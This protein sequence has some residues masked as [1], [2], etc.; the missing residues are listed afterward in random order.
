M[1]LESMNSSTEPVISPPEKD[2]RQSANWD[3][4]NAPKNYF[5]LVVSQG[6]SAFFAFAA[7]WLISKKIGSEGYGGVIAIIAASQV[8]QILVNWTCYS[9]VRF[10]TEEFVNTA[11]IASTFWL[12]F[13]VLAVNLLL[14]VLASN[15]WFPP[16]ADWLKLPENSFWFVILH[17]AAS[18]FWLHVQFGLQGAKLPRVSGFLLT[19]E[20]FIIL[21]G[22]ILL[23]WIDNLT[24]LSALLCYSISPFLMIF[25]GTFY[26]KPYLFS[27]FSIDPTFIKKI[28]AYS[29]PLLPFSLI[30]YFSGSYVDAIFVS[31]FLS[32][33]DLG[34]YSIATQINGITLQLPTLANSLLLPFFVTLQTGK[35]FEITNQYFKNVLPSLTLFWGVGCILLA[36]AFDLLIPIIFGEE[37]R[38]AGKALWIL[39][40]AS[41]ISASALFGYTAL[42][43]AVSATYISTVA[44]IFS[45]ATNILLN[46]L[47]IPRYGLIGCAWAT[48]FS[49]LIS[50][51]SIIF[52]T[53]RISGVSLSWL[54]FATLPAALG[55]VVFSVWNNSFSGLA[56]SLALA[57]ITMIVFKNSLKQTAIILNNIRKL[58][59]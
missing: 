28:V 20:R 53:Y 26:L 22:I 43:H 16:L 49:Y 27:H 38:D 35:K 7:V 14:V 13:L 40:S 46:F 31:K 19:V 18:A 59:N 34:V 36:F 9:V 54:F 29:L 24:P 44:A 45:S 39:L 55:L 37:F 1:T 8:A 15:L 33:K 2:E 6:F 56:V 48:F 17:F 52:L 42:S 41:A 47:L 23:I 5:S 11:R 12:R 57:V 3:I 25:I 58:Q 51:I 30:G 32:I 50:S 21:L 4:R 10:G